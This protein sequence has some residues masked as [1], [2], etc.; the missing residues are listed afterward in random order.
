MSSPVCGIVAV[1]RSIIGLGKIIL[2]LEI[3]AGYGAVMSMGYRRERRYL[4]KYLK[5]PR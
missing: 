2:R 1:S 5:Y 3:L 4:A